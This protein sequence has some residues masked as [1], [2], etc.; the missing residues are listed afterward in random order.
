VWFDTA[1]T[2]WVETSSFGAISAPVSR[3]NKLQVGQKSVDSFPY[4][5]APIAAEFLSSEL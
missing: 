2:T 1:V 3:L 4:L 5:R